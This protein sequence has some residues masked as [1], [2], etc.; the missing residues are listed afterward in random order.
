V[1]IRRSIGRTASLPE[2]FGR[3]SCPHGGTGP[4]FCAHRHELARE[5]DPSEACIVS[6]WAARAASPAF[7]GSIT[8]TRRSFEYTAGIAVPRLRC[9]AILSR[10][11]HCESQV[12]PK[13]RSDQEM[14]SSQMIVATAQRASARSSLSSS[15]NLTAHVEALRLTAPRIFVVAVNAAVYGC[16]PLRLAGC[17]CR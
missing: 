1:S 8:R 9:D 15:L 6:S 12:L 2:G 13:I 10:F 7:T 11:R 14:L 5:N 3:R 17:R 4:D 16:P